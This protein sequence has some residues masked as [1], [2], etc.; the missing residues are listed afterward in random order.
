[1][2]KILILGGG[3]SKE[4]EISLLTAKSVHKALKTK[5]YKTIICE[6][7]GRLIKKIK[8]FKP[9][10]IFNALHGRFGEDGYI[11]SLLESLKIKYTDSGVM[12][13]YTAM[14]KV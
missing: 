5:G 11:Q 4:R 7:D 14:D 6:P 12:A 9:E 8:K 10:V 13:S 1:M 2:K 3:Y